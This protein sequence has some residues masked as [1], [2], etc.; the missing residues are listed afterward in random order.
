MG[1]RQ[2]AFALT[3]LVLLGC[4]KETPTAFRDEAMGVAG[5]FPGSPVA[6]RYAEPSPYG[7][8]E[9]FSR[10]W[11]PQFRANENFQI[12]VTNLPPGTQGGTTPG[13]VLNTYQRWL[14]Q[15]FGTVEWTASPGEAQYRLHTANGLGLQGRV[16][17][18]RGRLHRAEATGPMGKAG[19]DTRAQAFLQSFQVNP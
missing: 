17:V 6:V 19:F 18:R 14:Q 15:R 10:A 16:I 1:W 7:S 5:V 11:R 8:L 4:G 3:V 12:E 13:E 2:R 9:W